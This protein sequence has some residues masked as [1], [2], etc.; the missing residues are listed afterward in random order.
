M[1]FSIIHLLI[2]LLSSILIVIIY[3]LKDDDKNTLKSLL[4]FSHV[5]M[6]VPTSGYVHVNTAAWGGQRLE[7][8]HSLELEV[9]VAVRHIIQMWGTELRSSEAL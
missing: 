3:H 2:C 9:Q 7:A 6:H 5:E 1:T 8:L 4:F